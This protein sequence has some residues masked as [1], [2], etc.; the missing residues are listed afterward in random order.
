MA[1]PVQNAVGYAVYAF[2]GV[3]AAIVALRVRYRGRVDQLL[4]FAVWNALLG[5]AILIQADV[6]M[7]RTA[8]WMVGFAAAAAGGVSALAAAYLDFADVLGLP[9]PE[10]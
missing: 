5:S 6:R 3:V 2:L 10:T 4:C 9:T 8:I 7:Y 1:I